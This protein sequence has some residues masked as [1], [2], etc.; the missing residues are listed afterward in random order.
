MHPLF[1]ENGEISHSLHRVN[2]ELLLTETKTPLSRRTVVLP[3]V[4]RE[5]LDH[6]RSAQATDR[7]RI[8]PQWGNELG[9]IFTSPYGLPRDG[10]TV[11]HQFKRRSRALGL[12]ELCFHDLRHSAASLLAVAGVQ[13]RDVQAQL[14]HANILTTLGIYTHVAPGAGAAIAG[15]MDALLTGKNSAPPG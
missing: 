6:Q 11:S 9:L 15:V 8:G 14:G 5:A 13:P 10:T 1:V 7:L 3:A 12:P 2:G 4:A